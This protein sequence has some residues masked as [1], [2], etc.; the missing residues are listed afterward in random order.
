MGWNCQRC[1][2]LLQLDASLE[3]IDSE[4]IANVRKVVNEVFPRAA[5]SA[6]DGVD[7]PWDTLHVLPEVRDAVLAQMDAYT[8]SP[9]SNISAKSDASLPQ[10]TLFHILSSDASCPPH[11]VQ[12]PLC[13]SCTLQVLE[14]HS[15]QIDQARKERDTLQTL[16]HELVR[17]ALLD[18]DMEMS[19]EDKARWQRKQNIIRREIDEMDAEMQRLEKE[20]AGY[21]EEEAKLHAELRNARQ[22]DEALEQQETNFWRDYHAATTELAQCESDKAKVD[23]QVR[24]D[25][26]ICA[27]LEQSDAYTDVFCIEQDSRGMASINGLRLGRL[28]PSQAST[29]GDQVDWPEINAAWGQTAFLLTVLARKLALQFSAYRVHPKGSFSIVERLGPDKATYELYGTSEW[30]LGRLL[31]SRRFDH[32]MVGILTCVHEL[33]EKVQELDPAATLPHTIEK[34]TIG[35]ASIRLQFN[36]PE[37]WTRATRYLLFTLRALLCWTLEK[38][39]V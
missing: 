22:E 36:Q 13:E 29:A 31:H 14:D 38:P 6:S 8:S 2:Q 19:S 7:D 25:T 23:A 17:L 34:D 12:H 1:G 20:L 37:V 24:E 11:V 26:K 28:N 18:G 32:A 10:Y 16:E 15:A 39:H 5:Q 30:Q 3:H 21:D 9:A 27:H 4:T 35:G 33:C